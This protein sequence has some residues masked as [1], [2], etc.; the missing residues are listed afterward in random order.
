MSSAK[1]F[2]LTLVGV[3]MLFCTSLIVLVGAANH[4]QS[5]SILSKKVCN[6]ALPPAQMCTQPLSAELDDMRA[7]VPVFDPR[8]QVQ[9]K[10]A[11]NCAGNGDISMISAIRG[12]CALYRRVRT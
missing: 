11:G 1:P 2:E 9:P 8:C 5:S 10:I 6:I 7:P 3:E 4:P 12:Y